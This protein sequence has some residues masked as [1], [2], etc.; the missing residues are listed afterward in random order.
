MP[1]STSP[2][3]V[4]ASDGSGILGF[5]SALRSQLAGSQSKFD[6]WV[7]GQKA[8]ADEA[9]AAHAE[10]VEARRLEI[11][12]LEAELR[13]I[14]ENL[15]VEAG[16]DSKSEVENGGIA[17]QRQVL[18]ERQVEIEGTIADLHLRQRQQQKELEGESMGCKFADSMADEF[19][20][21]LLAR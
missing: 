8:R 3:G 12:S 17:R 16:D 1:S 9:A 2:R 5:T 7:E 15:G 13:M 21:D 20:I 11:R 18:R 4:D 19:L 6:S 10:R 14:R